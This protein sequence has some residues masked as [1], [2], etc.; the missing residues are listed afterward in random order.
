MSPTDTIDVSGL[1]EHRDN[2]VVYAFTTIHSS[3]SRLITLFLG[4]DDGIKVWINGKVVFQEN[5]LRVLKQDENRVQVNLREGVNALLL[6][7]TQDKGPWGFSC[8]IETET[9]TDGPDA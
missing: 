2:A 4:S 7:I 9:E 1:L 5:R 6:K 3:S 8:R